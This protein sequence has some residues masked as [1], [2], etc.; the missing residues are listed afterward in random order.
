VIT[1]TTTRPVDLSGAGKI[2]GNLPGGA[3]LLVPLVLI[4]A[5]LLMIAYGPLGEPAT[6]VAREGGVSRALAARER[7]AS[8]LAPPLPALEAP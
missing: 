1:T 7:A 2:L 4:V 6:G 5:F 8:D 3:F